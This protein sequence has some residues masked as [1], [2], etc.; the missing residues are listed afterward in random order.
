[1]LKWLQHNRLGT[2]LF[3][4]KRGEKVGKD[5]FGNVYYRERAAK[6]QGGDWRNERRWVVYAGDGEIEASSVPAGWNAWM[7]KNREKSPAEEPLV[8]RHWEKS[9]QANQTGSDSAY[10]PQGHGRL[11]GQRAPATGDYEAWSPG[12]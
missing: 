6:G 12:D 5:E 2:F 4:R 3:T 11:G 7:H 9:H 1:M 8:T 10:V